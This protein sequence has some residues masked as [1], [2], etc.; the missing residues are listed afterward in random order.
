M[1]PRGPPRKVRWVHL[2]LSFHWTSGRVD[3]HL[4]RTVIMVCLPCSMQFSVLLSSIR[5]ALHVPVPRPYHPDVTFVVHSI[6][7]QI[8]N[9]EKLNL[10]HNL[11]ACMNHV[12]MYSR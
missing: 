5:I 12:T 7:T 10:L 2:H 4:I 1:N 11:G 9:V 8:E 6:K 3:R